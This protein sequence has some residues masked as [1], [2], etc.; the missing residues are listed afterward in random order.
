M[1]IEYRTT[2]SG[3]FDGSRSRIVL[4]P[5]IAERLSVGD[6]LH[7]TLPRWWHPE[8]VNTG[9]ATAG[10]VEAVYK[11]RIGNG[12]TPRLVRNDSELE[13]D[14]VDDLEDIGSTSWLGPTVVAVGTV[15][16][17]ARRRSRAD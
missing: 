2:W 14:G 9:R 4:G 11:W 1:S 10:D 3:L 6:L 13:E 16:L 8:A 7:I 5:A 15:V 17:L 12:P